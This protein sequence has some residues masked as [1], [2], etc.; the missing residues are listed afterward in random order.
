[1]GRCID[2]REMNMAV[3][4]T[5]MRAA[6]KAGHLL[7]MEMPNGRA[8]RNCTASDCLAFGGWLK[9]VGLRVRRGWS[10]RYGTDQ[11]DRTGKMTV[12]DTYNETMLGL[13][14]LAFH[15]REFPE[16]WWTLADLGKWWKRP[17]AAPC[18]EGGD[19][20]DDVDK[21]KRPEAAPGDEGGDPRDN[22]DKW[23]RPEVPPGD[24]FHGG[25][26]RR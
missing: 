8:L 11:V 23:K 1:M 12:G 26:Y 9:D 2:E 5:T 4:F 18:D 19:P 3:S 7:D 20:R 15:I 13:S 14:F 21:W 25:K 6:Y 22:I 24:E 17:E 16:L 10:F